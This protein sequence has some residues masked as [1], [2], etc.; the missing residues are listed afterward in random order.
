MNVLVAVDSSPSHEA[1]VKAVAKR[2][3]PGGACICVLA[4]V[5]PSYM[6]NVD[7]MAENNQTQAE[8]LV[9]LAAEKINQNR[10]VHCYGLVKEGDPKSVILDQAERSGAGF[11]FLGS[12]GHSGVIVSL[13]GSTAQAVIRY[14]PSSVEV[15]RPLADSEEEI[16]RGLRILLATDGSLCSQAAA[17][18][19]AQRPWPP[20]TK[21]N[22]VSAVELISKFPP[23]YLEPERM[24]ALRAESITR[25]QDAILASEEILSNA[26]LNTSESLLLPLATPKELILQEAGQWG[27]DLIVLGSHGRKGIQRFLLGSV[28]EAV[29][30]RAKCSVEV[31]R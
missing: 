26:G 7:A 14:A 17:L 10:G 31:I 12:H 4:V 28:S 18:S 6:W 29:A 20:E 30:A 22:I 16:R 3:W 19:V 9:H 5:E 25:S 13:M 8:A 15:V 24:E 11:I 2:P 23:P 1:V 21:V 27:A